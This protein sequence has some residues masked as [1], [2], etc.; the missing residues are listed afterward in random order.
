MSTVLTNLSHCKLSDYNVNR[1]EEG[2]GLFKLYEKFKK[3]R[4]ELINQLEVLADFL[5]RRSTRQ[6]LRLLFNM[7]NNN[8]NLDISWISL[9]K[10]MIANFLNDKKNHIMN[11][12][13]I[14]MPEILDRMSVDEFID[15]RILENY[16]NARTIIFGIAPLVLGININHCTLEFSSGNVVFKSSYI[17]YHNNARIWCICP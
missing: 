5:E 7:I 6:T 16:M 15:K 9:L 10:N 13:E 11:G 14:T 2:K 1:I 3:I 12:I 8:P 17:G 4:G